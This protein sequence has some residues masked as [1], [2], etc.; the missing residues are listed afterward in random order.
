MR[1][2]TVLYLIAVFALFIG[3]VFSYFSYSDEP[4]SNEETIPQQEFLTVHFQDVG[5]A[6]A[7]FIEFPDEKNI[8]IDGGEPENG[9][10]ILNYLNKLGVTKLDKIVAT[11]P[12]N[13]HIGGLVKIVNDMEV[14]EIWMPDVVHTTSSFISL[15]DVIEDKQIPVNKAFSGEILCE[16]ENYRIDVLSPRHEKYED[17]NNYSVVLKLTYKDK[18]FLF[19]GDAEKAV[20]KELTDVYG[21]GLKADVLKVG[22]HGSKTSSSEDFIQM[23]R[24]EIAV[25][26]AGDNNDYG[27]PNKK[28]IERLEGV[29]SKILCTN[30]DGTIVAKTDGHTVEVVK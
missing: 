9:T 11:H 26:S 29:N 27:H 12:H 19:M 22:H 4:E 2:R 8:L 18:T 5:N 30:D 15:L 20:E 3:F 16:G 17:M 21:A 13:D 28:V 14:G 7:V 6:D 1:K 10:D 25:I 24:P 23:V